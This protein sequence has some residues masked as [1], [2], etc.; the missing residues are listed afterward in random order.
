MNTNAAK[1]DESK[2]SKSESLSFLNRM[3]FFS[4]KLLRILSNKYLNAFILILVGLLLGHLITACSYEAYSGPYQSIQV[5][6]DELNEAR[7][8]LESIE[9]LKNEL[10][11]SSIVSDNTDHP[12]SEQEVED[13]NSLEEELSGFEVVPIANEASENNVVEKLKNTIVNLDIAARKIALERSSFIDLQHT[14]NSQFLQLLFLIIA[15]IT[16]AGYMTSQIIKYRLED[17]VSKD[18][19]I[20]VNKLFN[21]EMSK[22]REHVDGL[23]SSFSE[24]A[25]N[26][27]KR[28]LNKAQVMSYIEFSYTWWKLSKKTQNDDETG[29]F[30]DAGSFYLKVARDMG[31]RGLEQCRKDIFQEEL[32]TIEDPVDGN[33]RTH[34]KILYAA[35]I[36]NWVSNSMKLAWLDDEAYDEIMKCD[37]E[38]NILLSYGEDCI[39]NSKKSYLADRWYSFIETGVSVLM[40]FGNEPERS[41][42]KRILIKLIAGEDLSNNGGTIPD[43]DWRIGVCQEYNKKFDLSLEEPA[44]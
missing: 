31:Q 23:T 9:I 5:A 4:S 30:K 43:K 26:S 34:T 10:S 14:F 32:K 7:S 8:E 6:Q 25:D 33:D 16:A 2:L 13:I 1:E 11:E 28:S 15:L 41:E 19:E 36:N 21:S 17:E 3:R 12:D 38:R 35:A 39:K 27:T 20:I 22:F 24:R 29:I 42:G 18:A 44:A 40:T 37:S